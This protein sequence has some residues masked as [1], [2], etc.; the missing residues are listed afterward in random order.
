MMRIWLTLTSSPDSTKKNLRRNFQNLRYRIEKHC[1]WPRNSIQYRCVDTDEGH[2]VLHIVC[3]LP[4]APESFWIDYSLLHEWW[5][6]LHQAVQLKV[7]EIKSG[8]DHAARL[9]TY[10]VSQYMGEQD[11]TVRSSGS[12]LP[13]NFTEISKQV[14]GVVFNRDFPLAP[15]F[16]WKPLGQSFDFT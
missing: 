12:R 7:R 5:S 14:R 11:L 15:S 6:E 16:K 10:I 1:G 3:A 9:S 8:Q 4:C 13:I 2:G